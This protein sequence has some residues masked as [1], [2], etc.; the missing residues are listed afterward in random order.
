MQCGNKLD[1]TCAPRMPHPGLMLG[2]LAKVRSNFVGVCRV[3]LDDNIQKGGFQR[4]GTTPP[5]EKALVNQK[6]IFINTVNSQFSWFL[7]LVK[8]LR[9]ILGLQKPP[10][11]KPIL[12]QPSNIYS[13]ILCL[14]ISRNNFQKLSEDSKF[15]KHL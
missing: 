1:A 10:Y 5:I 2:N 15:S 8:C 6:S 9:H 12:L 4:V 11:W 7:G 14:T 13:S 3:I